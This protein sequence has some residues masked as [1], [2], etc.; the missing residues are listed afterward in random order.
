LGGDWRTGSVPL[1][2]TTANPYHPIDKP[3]KPSKALLNIFEQQLKEIRHM[4]DALKWE[5]DRTHCLE[6][7]E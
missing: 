6:W 5:E 2:K 1:K 3:S 4:E 7:H